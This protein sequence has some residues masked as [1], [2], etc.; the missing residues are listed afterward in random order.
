MSSIVTN[1]THLSPKSHMHLGG[2]LVNTE[3]NFVTIDIIF[4]LYLW[5]STAVCVYGLLLVTAGE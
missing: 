4:V 5:Y 2:C 1:K 3:S